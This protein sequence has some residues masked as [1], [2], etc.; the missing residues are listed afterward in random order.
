MVLDLAS[1]WNGKSLQ[2]HR[3]SFRGVD[4]VDVVVVVVAVAGDVDQATEDA[5]ELQNL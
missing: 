4:N 5:A 1:E 2:T 3:R